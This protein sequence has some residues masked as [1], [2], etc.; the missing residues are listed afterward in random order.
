M[1]KI[2]AETRALTRL[3][4]VSS[5]TC[6][7]PAWSVLVSRARYVTGQPNTGHHQN[8]LID[9]THSPEELKE[10]IAGDAKH[11][12]F[13]SGQ[14]ETIAT[15]APGQHTPQL[16]LGDRTHFPFNPPGMPPVNTLR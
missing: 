15:L 6:P 8:L 1:P 16:V 7:T 2:G 13:G 5:R 10:S 3:A 4:T 12:H 14:T 11:V 9:P